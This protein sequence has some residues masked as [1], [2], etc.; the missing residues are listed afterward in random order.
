[1]QNLA[2]AQPES[3]YQDRRLGMRLKNWGIW[4]NYDAAIAPPDA[5]CTSIESRYHED[6]LGDVMEEDRRAPLE[7]PDTP[8]AE[9]MQALISKLDTIEQ[10]ALAICY[11]GAPCVMRW[12]RV[13]DAVMHRAL[14]NGHIL[15]QV[16]IAQHS[17]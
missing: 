1:M 12:R 8:D 2:Y 14:D 17:K 7:T 11:G 6:S 5:I 15:L 10:Y 16:A 4:L 3:E 13:G 9:D